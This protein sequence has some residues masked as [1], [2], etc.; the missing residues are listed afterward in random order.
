MNLLE[1]VEH[2]PWPLPS[3]PWFMVQNWYD[4]LFSH[5]PV[6][7]EILRPMIP[8]GLTLDTF[9]GQSWVSI[10]PFHMDF[11]PRGLPAWPATWRFPELNCRTYLHRDGK[12]GVFFFS[13]D[14]ASRTAVWG[15][16]AFY[17]LPYYF[18]RMR[19]EKRGDFISYSSLRGDARW[20]GIYGPV[21]PERRAAPG[22]LEHWLTERYCLYAAKGDGIYRAEIHHVPWSLHD[23]HAEI[24][25]NTIAR[26]AGI[27]LPAVPPLLQFSFRLNVLVWPLRRVA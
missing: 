5:W 15:A 10:T 9:Q 23:A 19:V 8:A 1:I 16:R 11:R 21:A 17:R 3:G 7:G 27:S 12:P 25:E 22:T 24:E 20:R 26:S 14:A 2:R 13:L 18:S 6:P 4:L